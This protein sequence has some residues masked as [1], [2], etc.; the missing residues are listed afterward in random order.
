MVE[1][2]G[3]AAGNATAPGPAGTT[4]PTTAVHRPASTLAAVRPRRAI[5]T[6]ATPPTKQ[7][8]G[9]HRAHNDGSCQCGR[10]ADVTRG[11]RRGEPLPPPRLALGPSAAPVSAAAAAPVVAI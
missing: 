9:V 8:Y 1:G 6:M 2:A 7:A 11:T 4:R 10:G 3:T 5:R